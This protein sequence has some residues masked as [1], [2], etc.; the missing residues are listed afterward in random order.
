MGPLESG[1]PHADPAQTTRRILLRVLYVAILLAMPALVTWRMTRVRMRV[2]KEI[3]AVLDQEPDF[4]T[5]HD[6][7][8]TAFATR[9]MRE[10]REAHTRHLE[11]MGKAYEVWCRAQLAEMRRKER[12]WLWQW[13][14]TLDEK[15]PDEESLVSTEKMSSVEKTTMGDEEVLD[16][17]WNRG[18]SDLVRKIEQASK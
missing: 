2:R 4:A 13:K 11:A 18:F 5:R 14:R 6:R 10:D 16:Q 17:M 1:W 7:F 12:G 15:V 3:Y 8:L 9:R